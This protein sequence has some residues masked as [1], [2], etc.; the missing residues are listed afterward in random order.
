MALDLT[1]AQE[2]LDLWLAAEKAVATGQEYA[3]GS[4]RLTRADAAEITRKI[5]YWHREVLRLSRGGRGIRQRLVVP[6][7]G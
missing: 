6:V 7:D 4:R 1:T 5:N 3:I 2:M